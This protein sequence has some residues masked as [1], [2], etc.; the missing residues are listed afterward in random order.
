MTDK[1][2]RNLVFR[3]VAGAVVV[4]LVLSLLGFRVQAAFLGLK[5]IIV[6]AVLLG[7]LLWLGD[8]VT[9]SNRR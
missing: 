9:G 3:V 1:P 2:R 6:L 4:I 7:V 8:R 5:Y